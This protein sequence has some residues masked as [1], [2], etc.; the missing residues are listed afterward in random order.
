MSVHRVY[1]VSRDDGG[2][3]YTATA[4]TTT[5]AHLARRRGTPTSRG[6]DPARRRGHSAHQRG[7]APRQ[8]EAAR[9]PTL[10]P[11]HR[12]LRSGKVGAW[13][14]VAAGSSWEAW[15]LINHAC[16]QHGCDTRGFASAQQTSPCWSRCAQRRPSAPGDEKHPHASAGGAQ[17][18][19]AP[20]DLL[21]ASGGPRRPRRQP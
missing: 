13:G 11:M 18:G 16:S 17:V 8:T 21:P 4:T 6:R 3:C 14:K 2:R 20:A 12:A 9:K 5:R 7:V 1:R 10:L 19:W 15:D